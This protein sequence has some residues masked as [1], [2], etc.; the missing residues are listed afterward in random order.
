M[1]HALI[2]ES[3]N[4]HPHVPVHTHIDVVDYFA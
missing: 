4:M 1:K 2:H 3:V